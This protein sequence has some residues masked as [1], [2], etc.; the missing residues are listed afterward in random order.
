MNEENE[1]PAR[2]AVLWVFG[3]RKR[4][5][6]GG[7]ALHNEIGGGN[8]FADSDCHQE[9]VLFTAISLSQ[10]RANLDMSLRCVIYS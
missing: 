8:I 4:G 7:I 3:R 6:F 1:K 5:N 10:R 2:K 9:S